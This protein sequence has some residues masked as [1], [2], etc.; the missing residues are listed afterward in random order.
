MPMGILQSQ[1][2]LVALWTAAGLALLW[3]LG[4]L[5]LFLSPLRKYDTEVS[6]DPRE[7]EPGGKDPEYDRRFAELKALGFVPV[8]KTRERFR[9]FTP[10]H[11]RWI[12]DGTRWFA[13]PDRRVYVEIHRLGGGHPQRMSANTTFEGGGLLA[14]STAPTGMGG[15]VGE[16]YR[17]VELGVETV[18]ELVREHER[19]VSDF[20]RDV[21][22]RVKPGTLAEMAVETRMI[23]KPFV[24]RNRFIGLYAIAAIYVMPL[25]TVIGMM[26]RARKL[27]WL[28]PACLCGAAALFALLRLAVLPEFR[29][30]RWL[31]YV[32]LMA[33]ALGVPFLTSRAM[34]RHRLDHRAGVPSSGVTPTATT[35]HP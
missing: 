35:D 20:S 32:G 21:G 2:G 28:P 12:S 34:P 26:G 23:S 14:T 10:L 19:H 22:L 1:V 16:R 5:F 30:V 18:A 25:W 13:S 6:D 3:V 4:P 11:W 31:A 8:G 9:F 29:R 27:L 7:V 33:L 15:E 24:S 17:R